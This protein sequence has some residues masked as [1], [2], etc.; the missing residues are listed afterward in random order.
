MESSSRIQE[1]PHLLLLEVTGVTASL[2][3]SVS[4]QEVQQSLS[5]ASAEPHK[6]QDSRNAAVGLMGGGGG[7]MLKQDWGSVVLLS[8]T[9]I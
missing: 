5:A 4:D 6:P 2:L 1:N 9:E 3:V 7:V 8:P